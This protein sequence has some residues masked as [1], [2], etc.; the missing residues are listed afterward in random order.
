MLNEGIEE[1]G[2]NK[3]NKFSEKFWKDKKLFYFCIPFQRKL[4]ERETE[5]FKS[6]GKGKKQ[7]GRI[8]NRFIKL[9]ETEEK[10]SSKK[11]IEIITR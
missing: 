9:G 4:N 5:R 8:N 7:K 2:G 11:A 6:L 10:V 1:K 3:K